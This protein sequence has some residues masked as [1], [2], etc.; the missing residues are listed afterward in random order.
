M[1]T[2]RF[3]VVINAPAQN[4]WEVVT[5][6]GN[7]HTWFP[8]LK[9][10]RIEGDLRTI[11]AENGFEIPERIITNDAILKRFQYSI[12]APLFRGHLGT[13]DV[14][15][16]NHDQCVAVYSTECE[17]AALTLTIGGASAEALDN[18]KKRCEIVT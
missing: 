12:E 5:D 6:A 11:V 8:G 14:I 3:D 18:L 2:I 15:D 13:I 16:L 4:A 9:D 10:C 1:G 17:P 7:L